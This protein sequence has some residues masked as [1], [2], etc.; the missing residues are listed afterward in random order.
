[1]KF[2]V[3]YSFTEDILNVQYYSFNYQ[4]MPVDDAMSTSDFGHDTSREK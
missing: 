3:F 4:C 2:T 1:M